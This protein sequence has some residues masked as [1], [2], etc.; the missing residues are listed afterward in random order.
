MRQALGSTK[1]RDALRFSP[2]RTVWTTAAKA[3]S[4]S[5][6]SLTTNAADTVK[7]EA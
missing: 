2:I 5:K 4:Q 3:I 7:V 1:L 6:P